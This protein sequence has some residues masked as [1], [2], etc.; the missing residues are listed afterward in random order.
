MNSTMIITPDTTIQSASDHQEVEPL[1]SVPLFTDPVAQDGLASPPVFDAP[2]E[3][4]E[5]TERKSVRAAPIVSCGVEVL[6]NIQTKIEPIDWKPYQTKGRDGKVK[7][8]SDRAYIIRS[9][10]RIL[11]TAIKVGLPFVNHAGI[12]YHFT[13]THYKPIE[14]GVLQNFLIKCLVRCGVPLNT[15]IYHTFVD[16][17]FKQFLIHSAWH[18]SNIAEPDTSY[19]NLRNGT[20]F[21]DKKGHRFEPHSS[22]R[23]IRYCLHFPYDET[24]I[25]KLWQ[26]HL[27]RSLP[28]PDKQLY[29]AKCLALPF[30]RG[31]IEKAPLF[32]GKNDTGK[33]TT[34]DAYKE[35]IGSENYT[36]ESL[37]ALTKTDTQGDY[38]RARLDGK[39][40]NIVSDIS[41]KMSDEG[42]AKLLISRESVPARHPYG[43]GFDMRNFARQMCAMNEL[44][45]QFFTDSALA[46]RAAV[47][48][49]DQQIKSEDID[50]DFV[51]K[52]IADEL[53][54]VLNWI[55]TVG[56]ASLWETKNLNP[57]LCCIEEMERLR[58]EVDPVSAWLAEKGWIKGEAH[59][60]TMKDAQK[61]YDKF[62]HANHYL[63]MC[64]RTLARRLRDLGYRTDDTNGSIG[65]RFYY[66][67]SIPENHSD[68]TEPSD[69]DHVNYF[70]RAMSGDDVPF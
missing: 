60:I 34:L 28:H 26:K 20:L 37:A 43:Q 64:S 23:L 47:I 68:H 11:R 66:S 18:N 44:P 21:F 50:T 19:I 5:R 36:T 52:I 62:R 35:L 4:T 25:A 27:D 55:I 33:S 15:A 61:D 39:L 16:K 45:H 41:P 17:V 7:P 54:G 31:K 14:E 2:T 53:P 30:Y 12:I 6:D 1:Q 38:A 56:L 65:L 57:P 22:Q 9:I 40:A 58:K 42:M 48:L 29:L 63:E 10:E 46:K 13:G 69:P 32:C 51:E 67:K 3:P 59:W 24:A 49:F 70:E 8:P